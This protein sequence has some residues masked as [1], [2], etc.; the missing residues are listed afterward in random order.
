MIKKIRIVKVNSNYCDFLRKY[1]KRVPYNAGEKELRPFIGIL[2]EIEN[3]QYFAPL[4]S[5]KPKHIKLLNTLDLIK[6]DGGKL[7]VINL[8]NMLPVYINNYELIDL[9]KTNDKR[10]NHSRI[11]LLRNQLRWLNT[12]K[13]EIYKKST[14]LYKKYVNGLLPVN[15]TNRCCDF[16]LLEEKCR[17]YNNM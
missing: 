16:K 15:V 14:T 2:F 8:N 1:D 17:E 7:G 6:I 11:I 10:L 3:C 5:P 13:V 9:D 4:S 12:N